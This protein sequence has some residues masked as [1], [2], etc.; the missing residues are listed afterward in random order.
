MPAI[1]TTHNALAARLAAKSV[2]VTVITMDAVSPERAPA[3]QAHQGV[4]IL[5]AET[6]RNHPRRN[7]DADK[8]QIRLSYRV[9]AVDGAEAAMDA[10]MDLEQDILDA[11]ED[12]DGDWD[13]TSAGLL[14]LHHERS[15]RGYHPRSTGWVLITIFLVVYRQT[16]STP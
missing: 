10:A 4:V 16:A 9:K 11:L 6:L 7:L 2:G 13:L 1:K 14:G 3:P 8:V 5:T 15:T 12:L